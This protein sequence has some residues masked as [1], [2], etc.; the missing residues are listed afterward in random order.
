MKRGETRLDGNDGRRRSRHDAPKSQVGLD[1]QSVR[2]RIAAASSALEGLGEIT[3]EALDQILKRRAEQLAE[4]PIREAEGEQVELALLRLGHEVYGLDTQHV[5]EIRP[6]ERI[7][8]VPRVPE[9]VAGAVNLRGRILS[10]IDLQRFLGLTHGEHDKD[11]SPATRY[12]VVVATPDM[13]VAL[14]ADQILSV[15]S[16][17]AGKIQDASGS[18]RGIRAEYIR[19]IGE[20]GG[21]GDGSM[22]VILNLPALL[23]DKQLIVHEEIV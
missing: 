16:I 12:L 2:E 14:L 15:E 6:V 9:W 23:A 13:E 22:L 17:P 8:R 1:W 20:R 4:V 19:G 3:P 21:E 7:T 18:V 10:V 11:S 5:F